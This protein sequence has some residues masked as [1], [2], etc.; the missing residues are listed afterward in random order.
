MQA[1][2]QG[3]MASRQWRWL[4]TAGRQLAAATGGGSASRPQG[5]QRRPDQP[6]N[7]LRLT[8]SSSLNTGNAPGGAAL[9]MSSSS[10]AGIEAGMPTCADVRNVLG[11]KGGAA[12]AG[13]SPAVRRRNSGRRHG[14]MRSRLVFVLAFSQ[15]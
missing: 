8:L 4:L 13:C 6:A 2:Q 3:I 7:F 11:S 5:K 15:A 1:L 10:S 14:R 9:K 12:S